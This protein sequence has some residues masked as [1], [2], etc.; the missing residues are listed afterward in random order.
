ML[1]CLLCG[2][3]LSQ[4]AEDGA[5]DDRTLLNQ[6]NEFAAQNAR[7][8]RSSDS[9]ANISIVSYQPKESATDGGVEV[10]LVLA[11]LAP[12]SSPFCRFDTII[13]QGTIV[14]DNTIQC[15]APKH[16]SGEV[17]LSVSVDG[18][19]WSADVAF[20]YVA[21]GNATI[22]L[23]AIFL[24]ISL[25]SFALFLFQMKQCKDQQKK[26]LRDIPQAFHDSYY[27][28]KGPEAVPLN[29]KSPP[30]L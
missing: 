3:A 27:I 12:D 23:L 5:G 30:L 20:R 25:V 4:V 9:S 17:P 18:R 8:R 1:L 22:I 28:P 15:T 2:A 16:A 11:E 7:V 26:N 21:A 24:G 6:F 13:A 14:T 10:T 19:V 29:R